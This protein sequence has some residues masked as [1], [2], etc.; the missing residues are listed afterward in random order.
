MVKG[1]IS[2]RH[3]DGDFMFVLILLFRSKVVDDP[4]HVACEFSFFKQVPSMTSRNIIQAP[5]FH[6]SIIEA[7]PASQ[8]LHRIGSGPI[9]VILMPGN[10][11]SMLSWLGEQLI[12]PEPNGF[13]T[14]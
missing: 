9:A 11:A 14:E 5:I 6:G 12:M 1:S 7:R 3:F 13:V 8:M 2:C 4:I 10:H